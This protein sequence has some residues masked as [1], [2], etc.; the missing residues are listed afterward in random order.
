MKIWQKDAST[1]HEKEAKTLQLRVVPNATHGEP[2]DFSPVHPI[3]TLPIE[4]VE[5]IFLNLA[6]PLDLSPRKNGVNKWLWSIRAVCTQWKAVIDQSPPLWSTFHILLISETQYAKRRQS[7]ALSRCEL[8]LKRS[9]GVPLA[10]R[11][12]ASAEHA[13]L[14]L[15]FLRIFM[16]FSER[17]CS[18]SL[19]V[20]PDCHFLLSNLTIEV[21]PLLKNLKVS[22]K[23]SVYLPQFFFLCL[24]HPEIT[25]LSI[26]P[27]SLQDLEIPPSF[28]PTS[29]IT[30]LDLAGVFEASLSATT[31]CGILRNLPFVE[32]VSLYTWTTGATNLQP[33]ILPELRCLRLLDQTPRFLGWI[34]APQLSDLHLGCNVYSAEGCEKDMVARVKSLHLQDVRSNVPSMVPYLQDFTSLRELCVVWS[35]FQDPPSAHRD[36]RHSTID[37]LCV[38][39]TID[40]ETGHG[41]CPSLS[42]LSMQNSGP[43]SISLMRIMLSSRLHT[44]LSFVYLEYSGPEYEIPVE[45]LVASFRTGRPLLQIEAAKGYRQP[46]F[47]RHRR[48]E[49][50][51]FM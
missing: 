25:N 49:R 37:H 46:Y 44:S 43:M 11:F 15:T 31:A 39:L 18:V 17:W 34:V 33:A 20:P 36:Q 47:C 12:F 50:D 4:L 5:R 41:I 48:S 51:P 8:Y 45:Q 42:S 27:R 16:R 22:G 35:C 38:A 10:F 19:R 32:T 30:C 9:G 23:P 24:S 29:G 21:L 3:Q 13:T 26:S 6:E 1:T 28:A 40:S 7:R 2:D 14:A